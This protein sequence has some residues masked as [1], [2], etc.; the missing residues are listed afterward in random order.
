[1][2][3][4]AVFLFCQHEEEKKAKVG[5]KIVKTLRELNFG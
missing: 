3:L 4:G 1:M 5:F 2:L